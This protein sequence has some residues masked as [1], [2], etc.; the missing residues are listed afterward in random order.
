MVGSPEV[1][2][3]DEVSGLYRKVPDLVSSVA[4]P[5]SFEVFLLRAPG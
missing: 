2:H 1:I 5:G 3:L 4:V